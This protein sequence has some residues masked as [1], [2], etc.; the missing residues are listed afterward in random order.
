MK[1]EE[2]NNKFRIQETNQ[3][4]IETTH[5]L[6]SRTT[7]TFYIVISEFVIVFYRN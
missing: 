1:R 7:T 6:I 2:K 4:L 5:N 3:P